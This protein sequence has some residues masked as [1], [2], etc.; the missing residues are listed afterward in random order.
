MRST[1]C[2]CAPARTMPVAPVRRKSRNVQSCSLAG[3]RRL[4]A[5]S[6]YR[7]CKF[8]GRFVEE[9][10]SAGLTLS[11]GC[12]GPLL[13]VAVGPTRLDPGAQASGRGTNRV[14]RAVSEHHRAWR[15]GRC[16]QA[17][18]PERP[19][20]RRSDAGR[21]ILRTDRLTNRPW[22]SEAAPRYRPDRRRHRFG[23]P[24][25]STKSLRDSP[26]KRALT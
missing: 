6:A 9:R 4:S 23:G 11:C 18:D 8:Y 3:Q 7:G 5:T 19:D 16:V 2:G 26:L 20:C 15:P 25:H 24:G 21:S 22:P 17:V 10:K 1:T 13:P 12:I 14:G